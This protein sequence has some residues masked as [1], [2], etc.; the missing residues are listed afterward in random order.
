MQA[1]QP[2][3]IET[4]VFFPNTSAPCYVPDRTGHE[5]YTD[6]HLDRLERREHHRRNA[7]GDE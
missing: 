3:D 5:D 2:V 1:G 7:Q 4:P 6:T